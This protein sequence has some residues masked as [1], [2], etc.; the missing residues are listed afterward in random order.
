MK[1]NRLNL[2]RIKEEMKEMSSCASLSENY[3]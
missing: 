1:G 3:R 2:E